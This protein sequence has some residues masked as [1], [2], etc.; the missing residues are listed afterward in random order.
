MDNANKFIETHID[1]LEMIKQAKAGLTI[2]EINEDNFDPFDESILSCFL[3]TLPIEVKKVHKRFVSPVLVFDKSKN[4]YYPLLF[5]TTSYKDGKLYIDHSVY[6]LNPV[7]TAF[8]FELGIDLNDEINGRVLFAFIDSIKKKIFEKKLLNKVDLLYGLTDFDVADIHYVQAMPFLNQFAKGEEYPVKYQGL[9]KE[10]KDSE[11]EKEVSKI[12]IGFLARFERS[13]KRL[14]GY[15]SEK[16]SYQGK[17]AFDYIV[18][19]FLY[20]V[21]RNKENTLFVVPKS[22]KEE[23]L[24]FLKEEKLMDFCFDY[25]D[26]NFVKSLQALKKELLKPL[27]V[28]EEIKVENF[29]LN[30]ERY[31]NFVDKKYEITHFSNFRRN[32]RKFDFLVN[33]ID[34]TSYLPPLDISDYT[35][36]EF[37]KDYDY[38]NRLDSYE[39][40]L[41]S[42]VIDHPYYGLT[43]TAKEEN[44]QVINAL[45]DDLCNEITALQ[46]EIKE[47]HFLEDYNIQINNFAELEKYLDDLKI[48]SEYNGFPRKYFK[49]NQNNS[50]YYALSHL[51]RRYQNLSSAKLIMDNFF[52]EEIYKE[53]IDAMVKEYENGSFFGKK[54][55]KK[56]ILSYF[57]LKKSNDFVT[58][59]RVIKGYL[60][61]KIELDGLLP[62]Y[63][64]VY[65]DNVLTMNGVVEI[66]SNI[67]YIKKFKNHFKDDDDF[68]MNHPFIK[69]YLKDKD[70]RINM[71]SL[72]KD[73]ALLYN[74]IQKNINQLIGYFLQAPRDYFKYSFT[75]ILKHLQKLKNNSIKQFMDYASFNTGLE[76]ASF[77]LQLTVRSYMRKQRPLS[78]LKREYFMALAY[79]KYHRGRKLFEPYLQSYEK[80]E[81]AYLDDLSHYEEISRLLRYQS[82]QTH[83]KENLTECDFDKLITEEEKEI[84]EKNTDAQLKDEQIKLLSLR[85]PIGIVSFDDSVYLNDDSYNHVVIFDSMLMNNFELI[86]S[87]RLGKDV[88]LLSDKTIFDMRTQGYH[89]TLINRDVIY[90]SG[91]DFTILSEKFLSMF[92][93][94]FAMQSDERYLF[95]YKEN[96]I[97]YALLPDIVLSHEHDVRYLAL[98]A[99]FLAKEEGLILVNIDCQEYLFEKIDN[100]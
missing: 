70:F 69:R 52:D 88:L 86:N 99:R 23:L 25:N 21:I 20:E 26:A 17:D 18:L 80:V 14:E 5:L 34:K 77:L 8:F 97:E 35:E 15:K 9:F 19:G 85:Y 51:K 29:L 42:Y 95:I 30:E 66:E 72:G 38:L 60:A 58:I 11:I 91:F 10:L 12:D 78:Y 3:H 41:N 65:G 32:E 2:S 45:I 1:C 57:K 83:L 16:I 100:G 28:Q 68:S 89:D 81:S 61:A 82:I 75:A 98:L 76:Q 73:V 49:L 90:K 46:K 92:K 87:F 56:R 43:A 13:K 48:L 59:L 22:E 33:S 71:Q 55:A 39:S 79:A 63:Q 27:S 84:L 64:D 37:E 7:A 96:D 67:A 94:D 74:E 54:K 44:Y 36:E 62:M 31:I 53:D 50:E 4:C 6:F 40:V 24:H 93:E 47:D